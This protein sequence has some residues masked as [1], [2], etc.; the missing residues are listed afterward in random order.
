VGEESRVSLPLAE[1]LA[2]LSMENPTRLA[3]IQSPMG[4]FA[5]AGAVIIDLHLLGRL[6]DVGRGL[7]VVDATATG[8]ETLDDVLGWIA[9]DAKPWT[10]ER[11]VRRLDQRLRL[12]GCMER[13]LDHLVARGIV[14]CEKVRML[15]LFRMPTYL[16]AD[17][18]PLLDL[19][20]RIRQ[21]GPGP[22]DPR[23]AAL[24]GLARAAFRF[25]PATPT[26]R[27]QH[28]PRVP[29]P[30]PGT[31]VGTGRILAGTSTL[32]LVRAVLD[33]VTRATRD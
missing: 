16:V 6:A 31:W 17:E 22:V 27:R 32:P 14:R 11:W 33:E 1:E 12:E 19:M 18:G 4:Y 8:D 25:N 21:V 23:M 29:A 26:H 24:V 9:G 30:P 7:V 13:V 5:F 28:L 2:L 20:E 3:T 15:L 10:A